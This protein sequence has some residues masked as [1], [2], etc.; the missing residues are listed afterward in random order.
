MLTIKFYILK[1]SECP[2]CQS[3]TYGFYSAKMVNISKWR[4]TLYI[5]QVGP[6]MHVFQ[7]MHMFL[8]QFSWI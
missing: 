8:G 3:E 1:K 2:V 5:L 6:C 7:V 4:A